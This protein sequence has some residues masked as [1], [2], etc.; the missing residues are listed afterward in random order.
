ML[1]KLLPPAAA[2]ALA[3]FAS[4]GETVVESGKDSGKP[5]G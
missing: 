4:C 5:A 1:K 3:L 2:S